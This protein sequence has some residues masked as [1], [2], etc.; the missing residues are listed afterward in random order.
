MGVGVA[1]QHP[2]NDWGDL[3]GGYDLSRVKTP[4]VWSLAGRGRPV[5]FYLDD[6]RFEP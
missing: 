5:T 6:V 2:A 1:W 3:P 4:F